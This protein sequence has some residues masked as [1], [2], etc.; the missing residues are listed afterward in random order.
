MITETHLNMHAQACIHINLCAHGTHT[1]N[2]CTLETHLQS[3]L[4]FARDKQPR[5]EVWSVY[6][7]RQCT[8]SVWGCSEWGIRK[9]RR[10]RTVVQSDFAK[11]ACPQIITSISQH[12]CHLSASH[13]LR[14]LPPKMSCT[15]KSSSTG[16][17]TCRLHTP[18]TR[19]KR[20]LSLQLLFSFS[21]AKI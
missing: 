4:G 11:A 13:R 16:R 1:C 12:P 8:V 18:G 9:A 20:I 5:C 3:M 14:S 15:A 19:T 7:S 21:W 10:H 17:H 2:V 6:L